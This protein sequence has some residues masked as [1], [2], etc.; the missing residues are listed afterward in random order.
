MRRALAG[1]AWLLL[2][3]ALAA[4]VSKASGAAVASHQ[5]VV[6]LLGPQN[7]RGEPEVASRPL[8]SVGARSPLTAARTVLP[9]LAH[10]I[11]PR[12]RTWLRVRL[13]GRALGQRP[14]P[15]VGWIVASHTLRSITSWHIVVDLGERRVLVYRGGRRVRGYRAIVGARSTPTPLGHYFVEENVRLPAGRP[16]APFALATSARSDVLQEFDG[17]PGQIALHGRANI[18]GRLGTAVSHGCIRLG[19]RA[20]RWLGA[21]MGP[22]VPVTVRR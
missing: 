11:D 5:E 10:R 9:V 21:H 17:G 3:P 22:G 6:T 18:G 8:G 1:A 20:I 19:D 4:P 12:G 14:P 13:P 15:R 7:V 16:G 2:V